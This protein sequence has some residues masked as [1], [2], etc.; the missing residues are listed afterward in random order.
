[1]VIDAL[2]EWKFHQSKDDSKVVLCISLF[3]CFFYTFFFIFS[4]LLAEC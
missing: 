1:M 2:K 3:V 4:D